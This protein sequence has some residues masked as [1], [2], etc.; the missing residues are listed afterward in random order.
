MQGFYRLR[1]R[2]LLADWP[3]FDANIGLVVR[4]SSEQAARHLASQASG[5][6]GKNVWLDA[7]AST[8]ERLSLGGDD[9]IILIDHLRD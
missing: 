9:E 5:R 2:S 8:C 1:A 6:E 7:R 3:M 4:A